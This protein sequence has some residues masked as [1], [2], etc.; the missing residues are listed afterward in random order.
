MEKNKKEYTHNN[1]TGKY[2]MTRNMP[3]IITKI[4]K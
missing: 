1:K 4:L 3:T 2:F